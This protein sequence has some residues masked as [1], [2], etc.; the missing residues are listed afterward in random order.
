MGKPRVIDRLR[1]WWH[2]NV[3]CRLGRHEGERSCG[4]CGERLR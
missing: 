1:A 2:L 3:A 4:W